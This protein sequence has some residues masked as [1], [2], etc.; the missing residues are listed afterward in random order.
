MGFSA[1]FNVISRLFAPFFPFFPCEPE[2][3]GKG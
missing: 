1:S 2:K 3:D